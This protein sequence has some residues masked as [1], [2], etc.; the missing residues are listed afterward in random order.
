MAG[1]GEILAKS[2]PWPGYINLF[3]GKL[4]HDFNDDS[5]L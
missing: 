2:N 3:K 1:Q 4:A 5:F